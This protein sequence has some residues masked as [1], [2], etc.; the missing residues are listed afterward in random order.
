MVAS[1]LVLAASGLIAYRVFAP[2]EVLTS[3]SVPYPDVA[4]IT[5]D[6]PFSE[7]RAA[8]LVVEGRLRVYA[9]R[10]RVWSDA[11]VGERY[12]RTPYWSFR[13]WPAQVVGVVLAPTANGGTVVVSQWSDGEIVAID[14]RR[15]VIAWRDSAPTGG[16]RGYDGRRT[17]AAVVYTPRSLVTVRAPDRTVIIVTTDGEM[18]GFDAATGERRWTRALGQGCEPAA[19]T[20]AGLVV[21]PACDSADLEFFDGNS[22]EERGRW[23]AP[24]PAATPAPGLCEGSRTECRVVTVGFHTWLLGADGTMTHVPDLER[25]AQLAGE[26]VIYQ[27]GLGVAARRITDV[28]SLWTWQ[29]RGQL[30][31]ADPS[32][33]YLLTE[34]RTVLQLS[35]ATGRLAGVGC[36][37]ASDQNWQVGHIYPAGNYLALERVNRGVPSSASDQ[38]YFFGPFPVALVEI[39]SPTKLPQWPGKFAACAP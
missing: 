23:G 30:I 20:G 1:L 32:G 33:V 25:G 13:R 39:Y 8:P 14:A 29:G 36:A 7:L 34:G 12:E 5:D 26:R 21:A 37:A 11:P 17:G 4:V 31:S 35:P 16:P 9:E 6:R 19:W 2:H 24:D 28:D 18:I 22:G 3:P 38:A 15:G 27:T 10:Y